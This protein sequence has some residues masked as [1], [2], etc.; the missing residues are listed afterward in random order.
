MTKQHEHVI[1]F[2]KCNKLSLLHLC[3]VIYDQVIS[4]VHALSDCVLSYSQNSLKNF[5]I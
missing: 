3:F 2:K 4:N 1:F 5:L